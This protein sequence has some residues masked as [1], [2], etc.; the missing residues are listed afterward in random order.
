MSRA[1]TNQ[2]VASAAAA[3][4]F[5]RRRS[6]TQPMH[7]RTGEVLYECDSFLA[8]Y[9][10][11]KCIRRIEPSGGSR[12]THQP[13]DAGDVAPREISLF[14][15]S[16]VDRDRWAT[17]MLAGNKRRA[18]LANLTRNSSYCAERQMQQSG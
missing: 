11:G 17:N 14:F 18:L 4:A 2:Y 13:A 1:G 9:V 3:C 15:L 7:S 8:P 10:T 6:W 12:Q 16:S 5:D